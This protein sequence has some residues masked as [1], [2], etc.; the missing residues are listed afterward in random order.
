M[1]SFALSLG[2]LIYKHNN[3][4]NDQSVPLNTTSE[5]P[6][7]V[8]SETVLLPA[9]SIPDP[10]TTE[11]PT[12]ETP[13]PTPAPVTTTVISTPTVNPTPATTTTTAQTPTSVAN[14]R[15]NQLAARQHVR[16]EARQEAKHN[17]QVKSA[18]QKKPVVEGYESIKINPSFSLWNIK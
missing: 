12:T 5:T 16:Q 7:P 6:S 17:S 11:T 1:I 13:T 15:Q 18:F 10:T 3:M 4:V 2:F 8:V 9:T 14:Q